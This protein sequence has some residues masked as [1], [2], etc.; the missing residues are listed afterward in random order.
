MSMIALAGITFLAAAFRGL[1]GFGYALI[2]ALGL[3]LF[4]DPATGVSFLL[5]A[6]LCLTALVL[7]E[8]SR[9]D[10]KVTRRLLAAG[11]LGA[12]AGGLLATALDA[13]AAHRLAAGAIFVGACVALVRDP[14]RW[15]HHVGIG[16]A[17]AFVV[18]VLLA[19]VAVGGP[20]IAAWLLT[21]SRDRA[22]LT[23]TLAVFFGAVDGLGLMARL[24]L[25]AIGPDVP[26][27]LGLLALPTLAGFALGRSVAARL[28]FETWRRLSSGGL[29]AIAAGG[30]AQILLG[31]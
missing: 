2:A 18:G 27:T 11:L 26:A 12:L 3:P 9:V 20:L 17:I 1:T 8:G 7:R 30:L 15:L 13:E 19:S 5:V 29:M 31:L 6:D 14:P 25:G 4:A 21:R 24:A 10:W 16:I 22:T 23:G 28:D